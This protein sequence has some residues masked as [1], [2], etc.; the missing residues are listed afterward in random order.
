MEYKDL[1]DTYRKRS[2]ASLTDG[3]TTA[4]SHLDEV[5]VSLGLMEDSG[6]LAELMGA[7]SLGLPFAVIAVTEQ[8]AVV[9]KKKT[10]KAALQ[11]GTFRALKTGAGL[12]AG[13]AAM[14]A[15]LGALPAVPIA[16][17]VRLMLDKY[18]SQTL[19][20]YRVRQRSQRLKALISEREKRLQGT[21]EVPPA[22]G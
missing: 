3:I 4:L 7:L 6:L 20:A 13:A 9:L 19:T 8:G 10:Q 11:D 16:V 15:G 21:I 22:P 18:R 14:A 2:K 1:L 5:S 12:A 17:T